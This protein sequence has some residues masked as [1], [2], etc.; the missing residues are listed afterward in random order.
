MMAGGYTPPSKHEMARLLAEFDDLRTRV[1]R[2]EKPTGGQ[3]S[4]LREAVVTSRQLPIGGEPTEI[5]RKQSTTDGDATWT[6]E[7]IDQAITYYV[8]LGTGVSLVETFAGNSNDGVSL[9]VDLI[10][11]SEKTLNPIRTEANDERP[12]NL[13]LVL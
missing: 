9:P 2:L 7:L 5:I 13:E 1:K 10:S 4:S 6:G 3:K 11:G 12:I 8:Y